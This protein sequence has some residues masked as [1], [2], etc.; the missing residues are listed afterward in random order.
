MEIKVVSIKTL[1]GSCDSVEDV[2]GQI[3]KDEIS[4]RNDLATIQNRVISRWMEVSD[5][6]KKPLSPLLF[7][8]IKCLELYTRQ[9]TENDENG[10]REG[11]LLYTITYEISSF[12]HECINT[13]PNREFLLVN[14]EEDTLINYTAKPSDIVY[15]MK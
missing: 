4:Y 12:W 14:K 9:A 10:Y 8:G 15:F 7:H 11:T 1:K 6:Y 2:L 13:F 3:I 5:D